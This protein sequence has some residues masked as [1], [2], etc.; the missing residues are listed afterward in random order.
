MKTQNRLR[1]YLDTTIPSYVFAL[2]AMDKMDITKRF[3]TLRRAAGYE[4]LVSDVV[5]DEILRAAQPKRT[6]LLEQIEG[7]AILPL[8]L[9]ADKLARTYIHH[10]I[11]PERSLNDARHVAIATLYHADAVVSWNFSHL[12]NVRRTVGINQLHTQL[13]LPIIE[14]VTPQEVLL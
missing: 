8:T 3:M 7:M 13:G 9:E 4:M 5:V 1:L 2:D 14:I 12:V 6:L 11:M 10:K